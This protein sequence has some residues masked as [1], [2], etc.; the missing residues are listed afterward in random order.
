MSKTHRSPDQ[1]R[2]QVLHRSSQ[3]KPPSRKQ[4]MREALRQQEQESRGQV[5]FPEPEVMPPKPQW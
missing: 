3:P 5:E 2:Q 4:R 1:T